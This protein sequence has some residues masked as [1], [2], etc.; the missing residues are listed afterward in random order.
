MRKQKLLI[1]CMLGFSTLLAFS[2]DKVEAA[3]MNDTPLFGV[4]LAGAEFG[5]T[6][7]VYNKNYTYPTAKSLDYYKSKGFNLIRL[8]FKWERI[9]PSLFQQLDP[10]ELGEWLNSWMPRRRKMVVILDVHN[11]GAMMATS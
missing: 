10:I 5:G 8:P 6:R 11:Y 7:G 4:N 2:P 3:H 1:T 9:Q